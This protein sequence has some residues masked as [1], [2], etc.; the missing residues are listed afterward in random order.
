MHG[1]GSAGEGLH[2][3][4]IS[5]N[6]LYPMK[7]LPDWLKMGA[8]A[9]VWLLTIIPLQAQSATGTIQGRVFNPAR[10]EYARNAEV[11]IEGT[12]RVAYTE[13]DGSFRFANVPAGSVTVTVTYIGY[14][15]VNETFTVT[16]GQTA[17]REINITSTAARAGQDGIVELQAFTVASEREG[18]A[19]AIMEQRRNMDIVTSVSSDIFGDVTDGNVGEFLKYL[20]GVDLDYVESEARGPRLGGMDAQYTGVS[21][22]GVRMA[23]ADANRTGEAGRA[24]SF[25]SFA[26]TSIESIEIS[27]TTSPESPASSPSGTINMKTRRAF[28]RKGR[29]FSYNVSLNFNAEEFGL[30]KRLGPDE[31][32]NYKWRPNGSFEYAD[33]FMGGRLGILLGVSHAESYTEQYDMNISYNKSPTAADP[34]PMVIREIN[35]KDGPKW[36]FKDALTFTADFK[37]TDRLVLSLNTIYTRT[38]GE[39]WNRNFT[40]RAANNNNNVNNGR[41]TVIQ[42][43]N[44]T[45]IRTATASNNNLPRI[46]NGGGSSAK[47]T[48]ARTISPRFEYKLDNWVIDGAATYS[49]AF[50]DYD[51]LESGFAES[52]GGFIFSDWEATRE[53]PYSY[54]W[55]IRQLSGPDWYELGNFQDTNNRNGGTRVT[56]SGRVFITELWDGQLNAKWTVPHFERFPT[57]VKFGGKWTQEYRL[58]NNWN[59]WNVWSYIGPGGNTV[60]WN[61]TI[62]TWQNVTYGSWANLGFVAPHEYDLGTTNAL[63]VYNINGVKGMPPR[64]DRNRMAE[65]FY[66]NPEWFAHT[67]TPAN[68]YTSFVT[69]VQDLRETVTAGY[70]QFDTR[71]TRRLT[72]RAGVRHERTLVESEEFDPRTRAEVEAAGHTRWNTSQARADTFDGLYYQYFSKPKITREK[73]Y[74]NWFP[75]VVFKMQISPDLEWQAG[76]NKAISRPP[77]DQLTGVWQI[78]EEAERITASN[79]NLLPEY[80]NNYQT[81]LAY[82]FR[83][84]SPGQTSIA[85]SQN[86]IT[87][88]RVQRDGTAEEFGV[89]DPLYAGWEFRTRFNSPE[90]RRF[91]SMELVYN[92]TLGFLPDKLRGTNVN[93]A[94]TRVYG[95]IRRNNLAQHRFTS[96]LGYSY[97]K[98]NGSLGMVW[99]DDSPD[100]DT[101]YKRAITQFD[102]S[103]NYKLTRWATLYV[104]G[105]N[106]FNQPV[107]WYDFPVGN[108]DSQ[109]AVLG[110]MQEY[111]ANWVFGLKGVF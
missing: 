86:D 20:P 72:M 8:F 84:R 79:V 12:N 28:D 27:R 6:N 13:G 56:N 37:A 65:L 81:R 94:Y 32:E 69:R 67:A 44:M 80:S 51:A 108:H 10:G 50:N 107:L 34:R 54:E 71:L 76:F 93:L 4:I 49:K 109:G 25:E 35:T 52:E 102:L 7:K 3:Y 60:T 53:N 57:S 63:T 110:R 40:F 18:N 70:F 100:G 58:N 89:T 62:D 24:T 21:F 23:S 30:S 97:G 36:I 16:A 33:I 103:L 47:K 55:T 82:Y 31:K 104:Q 2:Q 83:G 85:F 9:L 15:T 38:E 106:I 29:T 66:S 11:R 92:Q 73:K 14:N 105:R 111:G 5:M 68:F 98:F 46:L 77:P 74:D 90:E 22:D 42:N 59:D 19:K 96:R 41:S 78:N 26:I 95:N 1:H 43:D 75:A 45:V 91:R 88:L 39:F 87:N 99:R 61:Q 101:R 17:V 64:A 48:Y